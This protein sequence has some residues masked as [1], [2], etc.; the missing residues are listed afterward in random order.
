MSEHRSALESRDRSAWPAYL[1][2]HSGLPGP[3]GNL[4]LIAAVADLG[5][6]RLFD[7]LIE[8]DDE[9][10]LCCGV[11]GLGGLALTDPTVVRRLRRHASDGRNQYAPMAGVPRLRER[12]AA[13]LLRFYGRNVDP[14]TEVTVTSGETEAI[15]DVIAAVVRQG[16]EVVMLDNVYE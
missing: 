14:E 10:L 3:R 5:D 4:E 8:T 11:V 16:D 15:F 2:E 9:Y 12:I 6:R 13:E 1:T 7:R